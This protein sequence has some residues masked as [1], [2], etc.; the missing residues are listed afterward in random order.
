MSSLTVPKSLA[1]VV[2]LDV[3]QALPRLPGAMQ[4]AEAIGLL[5]RRRFGFSVSGLFN[6]QATRGALSREFDRLSDSQAVRVI[7][8]IA[9]RTLPDRILALYNTEPSAPNTGIALDWLLRQVAT[10]PARQIML[11]LDAEMRP[12]DNLT[13]L[14]QT[15]LASAVG[16]AG[17]I[18][19]RR[20]VLC[21]GA[22]AW[23]TRER[24]GDHDASLFTAQVMYGLRGNAVSSEGLLTGRQLAQYVITDVQQVSKGQF[25][26]WAANVSRNVSPVAEDIVFQ[27]EM[28]L[29]LPRELTDNL[30]S[31]V[32]ALRHRAIEDIAHL[33]DKGDDTLR[34]LATAKLREVAAESDIGS[35]R[36]MAENELW[37]R[38]IDPNDV[39]FLPPWRELQPE[40]PGLTAIPEPANLPDPVMPGDRRQTIITLAV[41]ILVA[42]TVIFVI[43]H[44]S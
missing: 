23:Q 44:F 1:L 35:A 11:F 41:I 16:V 28:P 2:G 42:L 10:L 43:L 17:E 38:Q 15:S 18:E 39:A 4:G 29:E 12:P 37:A 20:L 24:W 22:E 3:Y 8:Y 26:P 5:L 33:I 31:G 6:Q 40:R 34:A 21:A 14:A 19:P 36:K 7:V 27:T 13:P 25:V 9:T 30:R 32:A